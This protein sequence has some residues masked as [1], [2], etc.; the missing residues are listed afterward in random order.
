M[1]A[2]LTVGRVPRVTIG[3]PGSG[4][5]FTQ[6]LPHGRTR[7]VRRGGALTFFGRLL[8]FAIGAAIGLAF[9]ILVIAAHATEPSYTFGR[10]PDGEPF[11][12]QCNRDG[13]CF[14]R[15]GDPVQGGGKPYWFQQ[16]PNKR[17]ERR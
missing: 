13:Y 16:E 8:G 12:Q 6:T 2:R 1:R 17:S 10:G 15:T 4:L 11:W 9:W 5:S 14:G 3:L 7:R